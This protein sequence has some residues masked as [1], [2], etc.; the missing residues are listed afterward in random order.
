MTNL[1]FEQALAE[2]H[3]KDLQQQA[4]QESLLK[5]LLKF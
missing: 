5:R 1:G 4:Q 3:L 2:Q